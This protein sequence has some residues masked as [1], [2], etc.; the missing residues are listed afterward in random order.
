[1]VE[2][3]PFEMRHCKTRKP[4][5]NPVIVVPGSVEFVTTARGPDINDQVPAPPG[6]GVF[7]ASIVLPE[8]THSV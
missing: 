8:L 7:A 6:V 5:V 3:P 2:H 1:V 4:G